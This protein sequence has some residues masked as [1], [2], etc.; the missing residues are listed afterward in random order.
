MRSVE[1]LARSLGRGNYG[2]IARKAELETAHVSRVLRGM[3]GVSLVVASRIADAAGVSLDELRAFIEATG[4]TSYLRTRRTHYDI[5]RDGKH[6]RPY[7]GR[8][9]SKSSNA[10]V[11]A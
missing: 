8:K 10:R 4:E 11:A 5:N 3:R 7:K 9:S 2:P 6:T 1:T